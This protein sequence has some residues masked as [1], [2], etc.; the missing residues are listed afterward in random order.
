MWALQSL[1]ASGIRVF[2]V[3]G[4]AFGWPVFVVLSL[5]GAWPHRSPPLAA[6]GFSGARP[7]RAVPLSWGDSLIFLEFIL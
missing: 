3:S 4:L 2:R 5:T 1:K 6:Q 7:L